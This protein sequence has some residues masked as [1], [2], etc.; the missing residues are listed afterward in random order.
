[1]AQQAETC[2]A[3]WLGMTQPQCHCTRGQQGCGH[4]CCTSHCR[5]PHTCSQQQRAVT[6]VAAARPSDDGQPD[7]PSGGDVEL[8][9][10]GQRGYWV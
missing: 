6:T 5:D 2:W 9:G 4:G 10:G 3:G 1:M 8:P 7:L